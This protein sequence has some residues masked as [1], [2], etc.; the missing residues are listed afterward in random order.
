MLGVAVLRIAIWFISRLDRSSRGPTVIHVA[1]VPSRRQA[2]LKN[3]ERGTLQD[4]RWARNII[5]R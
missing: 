1:K 2:L 3:D 4:E 5:L